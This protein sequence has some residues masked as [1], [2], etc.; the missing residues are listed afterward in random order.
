MSVKFVQDIDKTIFVMRDAGKWLEETGRKPSKWWRLKN[1]SRKF[2]LQYAKPQEFYVG[3][4]ESKPA[5]A[6]I[7]QLS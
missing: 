5:V 3:L 6:A 4:A 1:L 2:L 7:L